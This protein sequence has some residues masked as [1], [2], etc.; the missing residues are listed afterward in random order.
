MGGYQQCTVS[1][2]HANISIYDRGLNYWKFQIRFIHAYCYCCLS[3]MHGLYACKSGGVGSLV[4]IWLSKHN[5]RESKPFE[6]TDSFFWH[7]CNSR[8]YTIFG[9]KSPYFQAFLECVKFHIVFTNLD[10]DTL[11]II[12]IQS[13]CVRVCVGLYYASTI[14]YTLKSTCNSFL[15]LF[16]C[17]PFLGRVISLLFSLFPTLPVAHSEHTK[18]SWLFVLCAT[19]KIKKK[20]KPETSVKFMPA[21]KLKLLLLK[22]ECVAMRWGFFCL[23]IVVMPFLIAHAAMLLQHWMVRNMNKLYIRLK[24][25]L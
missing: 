3:N 18:Y 16:L 25:S 6:N 19:K 9:N 10:T 11:V 22:C 14:C 15:H 8:F 12:V 21:N 5:A 24:C 2:S 23:F 20:Q 4:G 17:S 13:S 7:T 1:H